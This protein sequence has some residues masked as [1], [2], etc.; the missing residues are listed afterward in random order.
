VRAP[1][2]EFTLMGAHSAPAE[3][4][5]VSDPLRAPKGLKAF[6]LHFQLSG[7]SLNI[8][9]GREAVLHEGDFT[10]C[11][12]SQPYSVRFTEANHMLCLKMPQEATAKRLGDVE[13]L[14]CRP[15]SAGQGGAAMLSTFLKTVWGQ[16]QSEPVDEDWGST[17][18]DVIM[19]LLELAYRPLLRTGG[20]CS[21]RAQRRRAARDF[22]DS[23]LC[24]PELGVGVIAEALG[25]SP[26]YVQLLFAETGGTPSAYI[27][28][29]R[30]DLAAERLRRGIGRG[31]VTDV[32]LG[33]GFNDVT[34][35]GRAFRR[36]FGVSPSGYTSGA[37]APRWSDAERLY[38]H[39]QG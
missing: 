11:D 37:R 31:G 12:A 30:L 2:G 9:G 29:R 27:L 10:L 3:V 14:L 6:D 5:R 24:D 1:L 19:D 39:A 13:P 28:D 4:R 38:L 16:L 35:F 8:Q 22:I 26:R 18:A 32:A 25:V 21:L 7:H 34:H 20:E 33:V 36:R 15:M 17:V 23:R